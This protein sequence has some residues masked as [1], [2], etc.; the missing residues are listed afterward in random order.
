MSRG[1]G[2]VYKRQGLNFANYFLVTMMIVLEIIFSIL[3]SFENK[4]ILKN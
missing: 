3:L 4:E 2:D 1:L